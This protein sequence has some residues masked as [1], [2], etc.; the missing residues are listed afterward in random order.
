MTRT[1]MLAPDYEKRIS[2][3][4]KKSTSTEKT[5]KQE[6][7]GESDQEPFRQASPRTP[8]EI[9]ATFCESHGLTKREGDVLAAVVADEQPLKYIAD[10]L[11]V[12]LRTIQHHL[13]SLYKK[14]GTQTRAGLTA[15]FIEEAQNDPQTRE[16]RTKQAVEIVRSKNAEGDAS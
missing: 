2:S 10:N 7:A 6:C 11:G 8:E 1:G 9:L 13:T 5:P 15:R 3:Y 4:P 16:A 12:G 14:T